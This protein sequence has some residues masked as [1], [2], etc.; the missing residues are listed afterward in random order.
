MPIKESGGVRFV[1]CRV[2]QY[3]LLLAIVLLSVIPILWVILS[4]FKT[5]QEI[6]S[7][8]LALPARWSFDGYVAAFRIAPLTTF[9]ANSI[10]VSIFSTVFNV[11]FISMSAY[12]VA[13]FEFA[14]KKFVFMLFSFSLLVP[15]TALMLPVYM[16]VQSALMLD[17]KIGLVFVYISLGFPTTFFI[18]RSYF[19]SFSKSIEEAAYIDGSGFL[20]TFFKIVLPI[21][22]PGM[23]TAAILQFLMAWN[24]FF[25]A[26]VLTSSVK[27]RTL[28]LAI[29]YFSSQFSRNYTAMF[30]AIT[31]I[32][33]PSILI[34]LLLQRQVVDSLAAGAVKG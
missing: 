20:N 19:L 6:L 16:L 34:Y 28:P 32:V 3:A 26:L 24:E 5:N 2:F 1:I 7:N 31:V 18:M 21:A 14:L 25:Y 10:L 15:M 9:Y 27:A 4:S 30:A 17:T 33:L 22:K 11:L 12:V 13:R 8:P 29:N 23:A